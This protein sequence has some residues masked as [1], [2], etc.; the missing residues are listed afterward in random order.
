MAPPVVPVPFEVDPPLGGAA[1]P[2]PPPPQAVNSAALAAAVAHTGDASG[3][4]VG[5][6]ESWRD[7][8]GIG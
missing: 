7:T 1:V 8:S 6:S 5:D 4:V 2:P 3:M